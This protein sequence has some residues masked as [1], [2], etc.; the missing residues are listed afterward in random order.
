[1]KFSGV[2][3]LQGVEFSIFPIDLEWALQQCSATALPVIITHAGIAAGVGRAFS[4]VCLYVC[5]LTG[6][7][8]ELSTPNMV[9]V[10]STA[11]SQHALTLR[12][13]VQRSRSHRYKNSHSRTVASDMCCYGHCWRGSACRYDCLCFLI[14][15][16]I[17]S[18]C[19]QAVHKCSLLLHRVVCVCWSHGWAVQKRLNSSRCHLGGWLMW[20]Q[21]T[22]TSWGGG[23]P[24]PPWDGTFLRWNMSQPIVT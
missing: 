19:L 5:A 13:K 21:G 2:T 23:G 24:N 14:I 15:I 20:F 12:S 11:V 18:H 7:R 6:K 8:L 3:I 10:Y 22:I 17:R 1:M 4:R 16:I 9:H